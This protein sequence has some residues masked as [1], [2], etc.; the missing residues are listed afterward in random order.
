MPGPIDESPTEHRTTTVDGVLETLEPRDGVDVGRQR[1]GVVTSFTSDPPGERLYPGSINPS[2]VI[3][4]ARALKPDF[5]PQELHHREGEIDALTSTLSPITEGL[6]GENAFIFGPSGT[7][8]TT[9]ARY[10][11]DLLQRETLASTTGYVNAM[12]NSTRA[13]ALYAL[14]QDAGLAHD[15]RKEGT[16]A[17]RF[18]NRISNVEGHFIAI[19]DEVHVLQNYKTL[20]ALWEESNVTLLMVCLDENQLFA[21]FDQQLQSR[22]GGA[23]KVHLDHYTT[24]EM[25]AILRGRVKAGLR[26]NVIREETLEYVADLAAG[27]ARAGIAL[28]RSAV[29]RA[30]A[31]GREEITE[32]LVDDVEADARAEM[33]A[34]RVRELDTDKRL[35]YEIIREAG[36]L[37]AGTLHARYEN[38]AQDPVARST[39]RKYLS[40]LG[41]YELVTSVG[42]GRGKR[43]YRNSRQP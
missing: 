11:V 30:K 25:T 34:H 4:D 40:R 24:E 3:T 19:I 20:Q 26:P 35:L 27:D 1:R 17:S 33:R 5:V 42:T 28:L 32:A 29:E 21:E 37:D 10:V 36:E 15:I 14:A 8:K 31:A 23:R 38:R 12:S 13:D 41:D 16:H 39:R 18:L 43:Y 22:F 7:G 2:D 9:I 6:S